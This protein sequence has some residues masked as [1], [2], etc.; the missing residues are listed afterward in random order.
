MYSGQEIVSQEQ[1]KLVLSEFYEGVKCFDREKRLL[2]VVLQYPNSSFYDETSYTLV[3]PKFAVYPV[4]LLD[5]ITRVT[6]LSIPD[7]A[8][9]LYVVM[10]ADKYQKVR[11]MP[12]DYIV[13][14]QKD[15]IPPDIRNV[16]ICKACKDTAGH[17][18]IEFEGTLVSTSDNKI[19]IG[20]EDNY[21][22]PIEMEFKLN[23]QIVPFSVLVQEENYLVVDTTG[24]SIQYSGLYDHESELYACDYAMY[25]PIISVCN[26]QNETKIT[27]YKDTVLT[28]NEDGSFSL[29]ETLVAL[30]DSSFLREEE[31]DALNISTL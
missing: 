10:K 21:Y 9:G 30:D 6:Q 14:C 7:N 4:R 27:T 5:S 26:Q 25:E 15:Y 13:E 28:L 17:V 16:Y 19:I 3:T 18:R 2:T 29:N 31:D 12:L 20:S 11:I 8:T 23:E 1:C 24:A 22:D